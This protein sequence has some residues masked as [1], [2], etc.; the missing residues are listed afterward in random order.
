MFCLDSFREWSSRLLAPP[1]VAVVFSAAVGDTA[2]CNVS[3]KGEEHISTT[4]F[5]CVLLTNTNQNTSNERFGTLKSIQ[6]PPRWDFWVFQLLSSWLSET[7]TTTTHR[8][9]R[10]IEQ[11]KLVI[12]ANNRQT[13]PCVSLEL[14]GA[15]LAPQITRSA[16]PV[17]PLFQPSDQHD[18]WQRCSPLAFVPSHRCRSNFSL[19]KLGSLMRSV[20]N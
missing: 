11:E 10:E 20:F 15:S 19:E 8:R 3:E 7:T 18:K 2:K 4:P 5:S 9:R 1:A 13:D 16:R 14:A 6:V 17:V 12:E